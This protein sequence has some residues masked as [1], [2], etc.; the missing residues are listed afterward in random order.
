M[1][2]PAITAVTLPLPPLSLPLFQISLNLSAILSESPT[3]LLVFYGAGLVLVSDGWAT[4]I[5]VVGAMIATLRFPI[6]VNN[7]KHR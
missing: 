6:I 7:G 5:V 4:I 2:D 3:E 1:V